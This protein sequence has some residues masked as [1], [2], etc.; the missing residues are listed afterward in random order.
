MP[1]VAIEEDVVE[2]CALDNCGTV[3]GYV[4]GLKEG[5][6]CRACRTAKAEYERERRE[7]PEGINKVSKELERIALVGML[8][9]YRTNNVKNFSD[10]ADAMGLKG[11]EAVSRLIK[12]HDLAVPPKE[13]RHG[14]LNGYRRGCTCEACLK[15]N[16]VHTYKYSL[17]AAKRRAA[18]RKNKK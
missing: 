11:P 10:I 6:R 12:K 3:S 9:R 17:P 16:R 5:M 4:Q 18:K 7:R 2:T 1:S 15:A 14:T 8:E 13:I